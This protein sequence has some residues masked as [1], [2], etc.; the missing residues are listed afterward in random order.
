MMLAAPAQTPGRVL[1]V[2]SDYSQLI[3]ALRSRT[4]ELA[5]SR[6]T[7]D[8]LTG[9]Q[10]GYCAKLLMPV[11]M[12]RFGPQSLGPLLTVLG[13]KLMLV[14]DLEGLRKISSRLE[15][16]D[17]RAVRQQAVGKRKKR[18][19]YPKL[20]PEWGRMMAARRVL[21][22][23]PRERSRIARV[24]GLSRWLKWRDIKEA[25]RAA[26]KPIP[27]P[28]KREREERLRLKSSWT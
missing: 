24:A 3:D 21:S 7:L 9:L 16:R 10:N 11:P 22:Q 20:G 5:V 2:V 6:K 4:D 14:E 26:A 17:E 23:S 18:R 27:P 19:V 1:A 15:K 13:A 12:K 25:A 8:D 28:T